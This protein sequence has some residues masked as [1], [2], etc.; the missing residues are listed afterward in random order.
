MR[1]RGRIILGCSFFALMLFQIGATACSP[2]L[3]Q[4]QGSLRGFTA[5]L[6]DGHVVVTAVNPTGPAAALHAG[7]EILEL[8]GQP[9]AALPLTSRER[10]KV[11]PGTE[12]S[13]V[14]R[15]DGQV[16][17]LNLATARLPPPNWFDPVFQLVLN[18]LFLLT[19]LVVFLLRPTDKQAVLLAVLL[20]SYTSVPNNQLQGVPESVIWVV[21]AARTVAMIFLPVFLHFFLIFPEPS[22]FLRKFPRLERWLYLPFFLFVVPGA[23]L[24][25]LRYAAGQVPVIDY[26]RQLWKDLI[27]FSGLVIIIYLIAGLSSLLI[28]YRNAGVVSRRK[29]HLVVAGGGAG[30]FNMLLLAAGEIFGWQGRWS[31]LWNWFGYAT[32]ITFPMIPLSFAYAIIRHQVIPV[33]LIIRRGVRYLLVSRGAVLLEMLLVAGA[34]TLLLTLIF[35]RLRPSG[36]VIGMTSAVVGILTWKASDALHARFLAP[37]IDRWFFRQSYDAQQILTELAQSMRTTTVLSELLEQVATRIQ[38]ALQTENV[39]ILLRDRASGDYQSAYSCEY[40]AAQK[41]PV[42]RAD[43]FRLPHYADV[44]SRLEQTGQ[45]VGVEL[46]D[47][48]SPFYDSAGNQNGSRQ[49]ERETLHQLKTALLLPLMTKD[50]VLGVISLGPRLGDLPYSGEDERLLMSVA[51]PATF[52]IEN[53]RLVERLVEDARRRQELEAESE[54]RA[55]ELEEARQLQLSMLPQKLPQLPHLE[56]AVYMKTATEVG[57]DYYDFHLAADGTLTVAVG[58]ATGHG[59]KAG[60][61]VT[62]TKSLFNNL[63]GEASLTGIFQQSSRALKLMNLRA[64][65]MAMTMLKLRGQQLTICAAGMPPVLIYQARTGTVEEVLMKGMPLGSVTSFPWREHA[66]TLFS[67]DVVVVMSDGFPERFDP[68][69]EMIGNDLATKMLPEIAHESAQQ[70]INHFVRAGDEWGSPR[71]QDDDVTFVILKVKL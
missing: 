11:R 56:I 7:D 51:G 67:G 44:V 60:T 35:S 70:M 58:D 37:V 57:G 68:Q 36:I 61:V 26:L 5:E 27:P 62:A 30:F 19:G 49:I 33:S 69:R 45:P 46:N 24:S 71:P 52:A 15:R 34:V 20:A 9:P 14:I 28:N 64:L 13:L 66:L 43:R 1:Q 38:R 23:G 10:W 8:K 55:R 54:Q 42:R 40:D 59:L 41:S 32:V 63:A 21:L 29:L 25:R 39:T 47:P 65:Y 48:D 18:L 3:S 53:S 22:R 12:F 50:E 16:Q 17:E 2:Y 31:T 4:T 6:K